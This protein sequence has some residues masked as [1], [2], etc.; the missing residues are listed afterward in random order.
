VA[1]GFIGTDSTR[2]VLSESALKH[3]KASTP[4]R[5]LGEAVEVAQAVAAVIENDFVNGVVLSV[6]GGLT[7]C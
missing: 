6:D 4:L 1:P 3:I 7:I 5:R 2:R